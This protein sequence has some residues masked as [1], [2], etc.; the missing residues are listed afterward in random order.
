MSSPTRVKPCHQ[1]E[2]AWLVLTVVQGETVALSRQTGWR[3]PFCTSFSFFLAL[4]SI[5]KKGG[6][7]EKLGKAGTKVIFIMFKRVCNR[8]FVFLPPMTLTEPIGALGVRDARRPMRMLVGDH[9]L[10]LKVA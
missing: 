6:T 5:H 4:F 9:L 3:V 7:Q 8:A 1:G 10:G 2:P